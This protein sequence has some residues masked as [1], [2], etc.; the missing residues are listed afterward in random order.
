MNSDSLHNRLEI[1]G[2]DQCGRIPYQFQF[3]VRQS[4]T[5]KLVL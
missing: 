2:V 4:N 1:Y 3:A 5:L